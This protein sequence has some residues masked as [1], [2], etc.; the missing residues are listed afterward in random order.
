MRLKM[1]LQNLAEK[2]KLKNWTNTEKKNK[3]NTN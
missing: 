2:N 1:K 3:K